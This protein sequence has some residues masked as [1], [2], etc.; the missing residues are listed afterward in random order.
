VKSWE[1]AILEDFS[2]L[3]KAGLCKP[4]MDEIEKDFRPAG[5]FL[6]NKTIGPEPMSRTCAIWNYRTQSGLAIEAAGFVLECRWPTGVD[7]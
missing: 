7:L 3:R 6:Q 5:R 2:E 1:T 4:L